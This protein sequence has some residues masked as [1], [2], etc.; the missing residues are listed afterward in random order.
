MFLFLFKSLLLSFDYSFSLPRLVFSAKLGF[1]LC[2]LLAARIVT[3]RLA[4]MVEK[5]G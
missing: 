3:D 4:Y 2:K 5:S 1:I